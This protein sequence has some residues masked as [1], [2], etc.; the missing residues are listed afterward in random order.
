MIGINDRTVGSTSQCMRMCVSRHYVSA[1]C[2]LCAAGRRSEQMP[3][4]KMIEIRYRPF[5]F[6]A[7]I[8]G[9]CIESC[10]TRHVCSRTLEDEGMISFKRRC[11]RYREADKECVYRTKCVR[12]RLVRPC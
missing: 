12:V 8:I 1:V 10:A 3:V 7:S 6:Y 11:R 5:F 2:S 4:R 9:N